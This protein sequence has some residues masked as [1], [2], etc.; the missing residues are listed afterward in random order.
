M[1]GNGIYFSLNSSY[2]HA[3]TDLDTDQRQMLICKVLVG[4][5]AFGNSKTTIKNLPKINNQFV[6]STFNR[7]G[8]PDLF[9]IYDQTQAYPKYL[10]TYQ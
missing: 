1:F 2:S 7:Y 4:Q 8:N 3:Y 10:I 6:D 5:S 9:I